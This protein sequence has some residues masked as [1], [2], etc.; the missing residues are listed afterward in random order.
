MSK[1]ALRLCERHT[2]EELLAM[3]ESVKNDPESYKEA[4]GLYLY[5]NKALKMLE[6]IRWALYWKRNPKGNRIIRQ[7]PNQGKY[8]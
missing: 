5:N 2:R 3:E 6:D 8:W 1:R 4:T 7:G